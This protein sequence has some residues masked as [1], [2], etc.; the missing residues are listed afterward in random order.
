MTTSLQNE[1]KN[2][3]VCVNKFLSN[4]VRVNG[5]RRKEKCHH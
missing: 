3:C 2:I 5:A 1:Y 4:Y